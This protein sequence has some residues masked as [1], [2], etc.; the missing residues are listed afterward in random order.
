MCVLTGKALFRFP[1]QWKEFILQCWFILRVALLPTMAV[2]VPVTALF[3]FT[4]NILRTKGDPQYALYYADVTK[5]EA[6][7]PLKV[8]FTFKNGSNR[9]L[10]QILGQ[11]PVLPKHYWEGKTFENTTLIPP[12]GSGPYKVDSFESPRYIVYRRDPYRDRAAYRWDGAPLV[13]G[14]RIPQ[15]VP[16]V[17]VPEPVA[18]RIPAAR[19]YRYAVL[20][21]RVYLVDP[22][23]GVI[24]AEITP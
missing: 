19:P 12:L 15:S 14:A 4:F 16:L 20:D 9:E 18:A 13:V 8:K 6:Q 3:I 1:F 2:S 22:A 5:V 24:V 7:A 17:A 21:N 23:S 10:A 11:L